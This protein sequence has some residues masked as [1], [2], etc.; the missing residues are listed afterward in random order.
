MLLTYFLTSRNRGFCGYAL[1]SFW[2]LN[3]L[4]RLKFVLVGF[5]CLEVD[6]AYAACK[7]NGT[8]IPGRDVLVKLKVARSVGENVAVILLFI[9]FFRLMTYCCLRYLNKPK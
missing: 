4:L 8:V 6:S 2:S 3:F 5:R 9:A 1:T 7:N